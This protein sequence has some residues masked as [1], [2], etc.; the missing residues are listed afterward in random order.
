MTESTTR[1]CARLG[2]GEH[3]SLVLRGGRNSRKAAGRKPSY[4]KGRRYCSDACRKLASKRR[5]GPHQSSPEAS[6]I[7]PAE[8]QNEDPATGVLSTV[9]TA[10]NSVDIL[11]TY[12]S[13]KS[14]R[15]SLKMIFGAYT[16]VPDPDWPKMYRVRRP[17]G[18]LTEMVNLTRARDAAREFA[19]VPVQTEAG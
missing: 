1:I 19:R 3:F 11:R 18:S 4:H 9:T 8:R 2:C 17:D 10:E 13:K 5:L 6:E 16:V 14:G 12:N 7:R 15:A